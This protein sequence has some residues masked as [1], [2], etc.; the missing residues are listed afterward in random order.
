MLVS[1]AGFFIKRRKKYKYRRQSEA[2]TP[3]YI[4][5]IEKMGKQVLV[6]T[7][8]GIIISV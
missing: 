3:A 6:Y 1:S 8:M 4:M 2:L 7:N 5:L